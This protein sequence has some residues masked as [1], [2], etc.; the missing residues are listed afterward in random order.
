MSKV[1]KDENGQV[2]FTWYIRKSVVEGTPMREY[3]HHYIPAADDPDEFEKFT[4][5]Y[6]DKVHAEYLVNSRNFHRDWP[7]DP[8]VCSFCGGPTPCLRED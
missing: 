1:E 2:V 6:E 8:S 7:S 4:G 3:F 5:T